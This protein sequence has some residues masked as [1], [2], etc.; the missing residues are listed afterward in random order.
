[1][2]SEDLFISNSIYVGILTTISKDTFYHLI[3][4][5]V[6]KNDMRKCL[7]L[8]VVLLGL[9]DFFFIHFITS[10]CDM[11]TDPSKENS[12]EN[13]SSFSSLSSRVYCFP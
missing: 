3:Y 1:V 2:F 9:K 13:G 5:W 12:L 11:S 7:F 8:C 6:H 10:S 4:L